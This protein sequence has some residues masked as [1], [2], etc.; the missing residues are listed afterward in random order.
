MASFLLGFYA[1]FLTV[2]FC[3]GFGAADEIRQRYE[4]LGPC[5]ACKV[6]VDS[7]EK[8][9]QRTIYEP[10]EH[11]SHRLAIIQQSLCEEPRSKPA[12]LETATQAK[13]FIEEW[14]LHSN[15]AP[16]IFQ[17]ICIEKLEVCCPKHH[18]GKQC[19]PC[20]GDL[21]NVCSGNGKCRGDGT[22]KGNG[23]CLCDPGYSGEFC[24]ECFAGY[25]K[26][27]EDSDHL[28][29]KRCH[30]S[31]MG[32]CRDGSPRDC[33]AC[34]PGFLFDTDEGCLD[35]NECNDINI[36]TKDEFCLNS[37]GSYKCMA[38][39]RACKGCYGDSPD[40]CRKCAKGFSKK[41]DMCIQDREDEEMDQMTV[42][43]KRADMLFECG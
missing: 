17:H 26:S 38:C 12:C 5:Q 33:V 21:E 14:W 19:L 2:L 11:S 10:T 36:C 25:Y 42:T 4:E 28:L 41:G 39:D 22:R 29:C 37:K 1:I 23:T 9:M 32:G 8:G 27:Y 16:D 7:F 43:R 18:Y 31:C 13:P 3:D 34:R 24:N 40:M 20:H 6:F 30:Y 35:I 15:K